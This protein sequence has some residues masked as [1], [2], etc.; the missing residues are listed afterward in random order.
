MKASLRMTALFAVSALLTACG[1]GGGGSS[2]SA[3][4]PGNNIPPVITP[5]L[6]PVN[7]AAKYKDTLQSGLNLILQADHVTKTLW[8]L[9]ALIAPGITAHGPFT[10]CTNSSCDHSQDQLQWFSLTLS[11]GESVRVQDWQDVNSNL[12]VDG[13][14]QLRID[15]VTYGDDPAITSSGTTNYPGADGY[16]HLFFGADP[17]NT[18]D[19]LY[20]G[21]KRQYEFNGSLAVK[22]VNGQYVVRDVREEDTSGVTRLITINEYSAQRVKLGSW[23]T[24]IVATSNVADLDK[25][26]FDIDMLNY[27]GGAKQKLA[28]VSPLNF[29]VQGGKTIIESG[30]WTYSWDSNTGTKYV[31]QVSVDADPA[32]LNIEIDEGADG[33]FDKS[34]RL[35]QSDLDY[36]IQ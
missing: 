7:E 15:L 4:P 18:H 8:D 22:V 19:G 16:Q 13:Y 26:E 29:G 28:T 21:T 25:V 14:D 6:E 12:I 27:F 2:G 9:P 34:G 3:P 10:H 17:D 1:G 5:P 35:A 33:T 36:S 24:T 11:N 23:M 20:V 31:L 32:Y 30:S